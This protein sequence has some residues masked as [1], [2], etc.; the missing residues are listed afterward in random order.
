MW[1]R[2]PA[3]LVA[4]LVALAAAGIVALA[5]ER[6]G[7][8]APSASEGGIVMVEAGSSLADIAGALEEAG[9]I[10]SARHFALSTRL[11]G[12]GHRLQAGEFRVP[13]AASMS[14]VAEI[15]AFGRALA[16]AVTVPEGASS[17]E[18]VD[19]L[20][21]AEVLSGEIA[22]VPP[23]GS[24][25]PETWHVRRNTPRSE[26][27]ARMAEAQ[28]RELAR[29]WERRAADLPLQSPWE[30]VI[31]AS[32]VEKETGQAGERPMVAA[33][34]LNRLRKGMRLQ[35][36]PTVIYGITLGRAPLGRE[37]LRADLRIDSPYNSYRHAG[38]PPTPIS[39]PGRASL[40]AVLN[41]AD[42]DALYF[43]A[44][45]EGGH[46]FAATFRE[47]RRNVAAWRQARKQ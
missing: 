23:E 7:F 9:L 32:I 44:D 43:V 37:L 41:P 4:C 35:A 39:N 29:L 45:G 6:Q 21:A 3:R 20:S 40:A 36:D 13:P 15:L 46:R 18:I 47:H 10:A 31:L 2:W 25:L 5:V 27:L 24:L 19:M 8:T 17:Q 11:R 34:F 1:T 42:S 28:Q 14:E 30:A 16:H 38:L 33:V 22:E 12:M 26:L